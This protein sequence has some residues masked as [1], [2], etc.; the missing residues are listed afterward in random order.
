M[1]LKQWKSLFGGRYRSY[2]CRG[3]PMC[4][5]EGDAGTGMVVP[6]SVAVRTDHGEWLF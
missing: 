2:Y 5:L 4:P 1:L 6:N 3:I